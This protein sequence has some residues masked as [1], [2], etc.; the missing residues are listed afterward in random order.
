MGERELPILDSAGETLDPEA[1]DSYRS[2]VQDLE[3]RLAQAERN[4]DQSQKELLQEERD[5]ITDE[6]LQATGL[7][8]RHRKS[9]D[10]AEKIRKSVCNAIARAIEAIH[11]HLPELADHLKLHIKLG[12]FVTYKPDASLWQF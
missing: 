2:R 11:E 9:H 6:L 7:G 8:G 5:Q 12:S 10:D 1:F 4:N 3:D